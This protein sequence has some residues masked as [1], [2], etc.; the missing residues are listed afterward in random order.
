MLRFYIVIMAVFLSVWRRTVDRPSIRIFFRIT[1][2]Y[3]NVYSY[4]KS[5]KCSLVGV[6]HFLVWILA[7]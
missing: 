1:I 7:N 4:E 6:D 5:R 3:V 2:V